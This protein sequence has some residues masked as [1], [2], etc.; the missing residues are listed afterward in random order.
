MLR[1][2]IVDDEAHARAA[3]RI[4]LGRRGG[5]EI[6]AECRNGTE[7]VEVL[8]WVTVDLLLLDVQMPGLDGFGVIHALGADKVP[9]TVFVTAFDKYAL[10]AFEV[11]AIDYVLKPFDEAR[12]LAAF[13]RARHRI[14]ERR[15]AQWA[16]RLLAATPRSAGAVPAVPVPRLAVP[17]GNRIVFVNFDEIDW[18]QA[19][20]QYVIVHVA[21]KEHLL[22]E[23]LQRLAARLPRERFAQIHRSHIVNLSKV[24]EVRRLGNGD[25]EITLAGGRAL[26]MSRRYRHEFTIT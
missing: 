6:V 10:R 15:S 20:D 22:R 24:K 26:R 13:D 7:A 2:A 17:T 5:V 1:V 11:E 23:S 12:F 4:L 16:R 21:G 9:P 25:A 19:A 14:D 3:I 18:I 8:Q